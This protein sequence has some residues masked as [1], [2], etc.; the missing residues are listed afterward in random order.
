MTTSIAAISIRPARDD[1]AVALLRVASLDSAIVPV[2]RLL[3][4]ERD[5]E[6]I[7]ALS[8]S[9]GKAIADPLQSTADAVA[10]LRLRSEQLATTRVA[11]AMRP[12]RSRPLPSPMRPR[13]N[14]AVTFVA[15][16]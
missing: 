6:L 2:G 10:L 5:G 4:A 16:P 1:D 11:A 15:L 13:R 7:A 9:T 3:V 14:P 12:R 8:L